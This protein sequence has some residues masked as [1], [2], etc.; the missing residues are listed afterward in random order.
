MT[1]GLQSFAGGGAST[2]V[3]A[4]VV[5]A[6]K[7]FLDSRREKRQGVVAESYVTSARVDDRQTEN[8]ILRDTLKALQDEN[9]RLTTRVQHLEETVHAKDAKIEELQRTVDEMKDQLASVGD[10]LAKLRELG[11]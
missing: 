5:Y 8:A 3:V 4:V 10:Q 11:Q 9:S 1:A 2:L 6:V 7:L